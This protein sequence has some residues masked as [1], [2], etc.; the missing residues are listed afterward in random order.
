MRIHWGHR[1]LLVAVCSTLVA[2]S[3]VGTAAALTQKQNLGKKIYFDTALSTP[4]GLA[5]AGC[6]TPSVGWVDPDAS[7]P[8][9]A[10]I[11]GAYGGRNAPSAAYAATS[12]TFFFDGEYIGGQFWDGR[13]A[14]LADQ[15]KGPFLNPVEMGN[16]SKAAVVDDVAAADYAWLFLK[17]YGAD[18]FSPDDVDA[19]YDDVADAI[20][21]Y[22]RSPEVCSYTSTYDAYLA[23]EQLLSAQEMRG[24]KLFKG[25]AGCSGCHGRGSLNSRKDPLTNHKYAN[26]GVPSNPLLLL[27]ARLPDDYADPGLGGF[28]QNAD[29][30][31]SLENWG[32]MKIPTLRNVAETG[33]Y[34]HNGYFASLEDVVT[35][36]NTRDVSDRWLE[37][38]VA[39][40]VTTK[41]GDLKLTNGEVDDIVAF[42]RTLTD[43]SL[44][45]VR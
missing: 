28:L 10:G 1:V 42:L 18:A 21:A 8:V 45:S 32:K 12:P 37:P 34:T 38:E 27:L 17:I 39:V 44:T 24:L 36:L 22:E 40:N 31:F 41:V 6:H 33:P 26:L 29:L 9:S 25:K 23:G 15:A 4:D 3:A 20:A 7:W 19:A 16:P 13:A 5:C 11:N 35:F 43:S 14:T 2:L 30:D